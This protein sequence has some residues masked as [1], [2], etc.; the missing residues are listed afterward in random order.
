MEHHNPAAVASYAG[1]RVVCSLVNTFDE[2]TGGERDPCA[3]WERGELQQAR[4]SP[5]FCSNC[6]MLNQL[7]LTRNTECSS[8]EVLVV[9]GRAESRCGGRI[10]GFVARPSPTL[11][12]GPSPH[13]RPLP[14]PQCEARG[15][16]ESALL[17]EGATEHVLAQRKGCKNAMMCGPGSGRGTHAQHGRGAGSRAAF[18][19][20]TRALPLRQ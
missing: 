3:A 15:S 19:P 18:L 13:L 17:Q 16:R 14:E 4:F 9:L 10:A 7:L 11:R 5:S 12:A 2:E 8:S 20:K 1:L 6:S